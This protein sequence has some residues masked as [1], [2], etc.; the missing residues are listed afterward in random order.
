MKKWIPILSGLLVAQLLLAVVI[1]LSGEDYGV[2][3]AQEQLI[4]FDEKAVDGLRIE[5]GSQSVVLKKQGDKWVLPGSDDFP[6]S[7]DTVNQL[8]KKLSAM[9]KGWPVATTSAAVQRFKVGEEQFERRLTLLSGEE[10]ITQLYIGTSPGF[11]KVNVRPEGEDKVF[12]VEFDSWD[13]SAK[14]DDW[15]DKGILKLKEDDIERV[16]MPGFVLQRQDGKFEVADLGDKEQTVETETGALLRKLSALNIQSLVGTK[17]KPE[18][19]QDEP[20]LEL[21]VKRK[22]GEELSYRFSKPKEEPYYVLKRSDFDQYFKVAEFTVDPIKDTARDKLV[23]AKAEEPSTEASGEEQ[24]ET[25]E[26]MEKG[27]AVGEVG[28]PQGGD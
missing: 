4:A 23:K 25:A 28:K 15:I 1:N 27:A 22:D 18:Y 13:A 11:R 10:P 5:D 6:A 3:Q 9:K 2:F 8:L 20:E 12:A 21:T 26:K 24:V 19:R 16:E 7:A 17:A 14:T